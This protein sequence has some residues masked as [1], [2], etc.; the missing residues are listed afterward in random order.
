MCSLHVFQSYQ[1]MN[2]H[3]H[4]SDIELIQHYYVVEQHY[5][6][7]SSSAILSKYM[8][9]VL[10]V[11]TRISLLLFQFIARLAANLQ[12]MRAPFESATYGPSSGP[13]LR[14]VDLWVFSWHFSIRNELCNKFAHWQR[15]LS[16][17]FSHLQSDKK[18]QL[19]TRFHL[20]RQISNPVNASAQQNALTAP[21]DPQ[22][23]RLT[24][25]FGL[26]KIST[27]K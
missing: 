13:P 26:S 1:C 7:P 3:N 23:D 20:R 27:R 6:F 10:Y 17:N 8:L 25:E 21:P 19:V 5:T 16:C 14:C 22:G 18:P 9:R 24:Q 2:L 15:T 12:G 11:C 4:R